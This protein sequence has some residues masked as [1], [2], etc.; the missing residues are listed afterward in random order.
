MAG[1]SASVL[2]SAVSTI[3]LLLA[4][5]MA[6]LGDLAVDADVALRASL[7]A[8]MPARQLLPALSETIER[9]L[10][11]FGVASGDDVMTAAWDCPVHGLHAI[12]E[13]W[14]LKFIAG[15]I[16]LLVSTVQ[17][18]L[19]VPDNNIAEIIAPIAACF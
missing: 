9:I 13:T 1:G 11:D 16:G 14:F 6:S 18:D 4:L 2:A 8:D 19:G 15:H 12:N 7:L 10:V 17:V 3:A 5:S